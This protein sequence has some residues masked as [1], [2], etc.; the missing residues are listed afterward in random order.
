MIYRNVHTVFIGQL[1]FYDFDDKRLKLLKGRKI[2]T[3]VRLR[4]HFEKK[5]MRYAAGEV[6]FT[7]QFCL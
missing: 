7:I 3:S 6:I 1:Y 4:L 5:Y 2:S